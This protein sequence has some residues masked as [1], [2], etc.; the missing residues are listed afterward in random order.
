MHGSN[1]LD[2]LI[3]GSVNVQSQ[4]DSSGK[5]NDVFFK[6]IS[7]VIQRLDEKIFKLKGDFLVYGDNSSVQNFYASG[8]LQQ[9]NIDVFMENL[10]YLDE[11][12]V[13]IKGNKY[14]NNTVEFSNGVSISDNFENLDLQKF[15]ENVVLIDRPLS[16]RK[17]SVIFEG[18]IMVENDLIVRNLRTVTLKSINIDDL[19]DNVV[20][21]NRPQFIGGN[22]HRA[23]IITLD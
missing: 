10:I 19:R 22:F 6:D 8:E 9:K 11:K 20:H 17:S 2:F 14:F 3:L 16:L 21:L 12:N 5:I 13:E 4:F 7:K 15:Y 23:E 18:D 1:I